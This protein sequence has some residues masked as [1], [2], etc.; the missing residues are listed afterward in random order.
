MPDASCTA[1]EEDIAMTMQ[2]IRQRDE[3]QKMR[4]LSRERARYKARYHL[5]PEFRQRAIDRA[6]Q[7]RLKDPAHHRKLVRQSYQRRMAAIKASM[8]E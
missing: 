1:A 4:Y 8:D 7:A 2:C 6:R 5:N 3:E